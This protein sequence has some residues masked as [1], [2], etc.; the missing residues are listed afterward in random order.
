M[1]CD[2]A[3]LFMVLSLQRLQYSEMSIN[4]SQTGVDD[5]QEIPHDLFEHDRNRLAKKGEFI[6][7][8]SIKEITE[9]KQEI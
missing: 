4:Q 8:L 6:S 3:N 7:T 5:T 1:C 9:S 2:E